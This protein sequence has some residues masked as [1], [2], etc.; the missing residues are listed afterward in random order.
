MAIEAAGGEGAPYSTRADIAASFQRVAVAHLEQRVRR[1]ASWAR[2]S[3]PEVRQLVVAG[4]VASNAYVRA[5]LA[6]L[7]ADAGLQLVCPP[8][9]LCTDNGVMVAWAGVERLALG[10]AGPPPANEAPA[11]G[12]WVELRP[13]WPLTD[14][15]DPRCYVA[16]RSAKKKRV[17][18]SLERMQQAQAQGQLAEQ[19]EEQQRRQSQQQPAAPGLEQQ[20]QQQRDWPDQRRAAAESQ[21]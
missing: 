8:P 18:P 2:E 4:G 15:R 20:W 13:R 7:A 5:R 14:R 10:L 11:E 12:E 21:R 17:F 3:H 9:A 6:A 19:R 16:P 1:A